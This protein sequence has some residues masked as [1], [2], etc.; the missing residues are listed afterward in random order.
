MSPVTKKK[1][2]NDAIIKW[3][4]TLLPNMSTIFNSVFLLKKTHFYED[5]EET[6]VIVLFFTDR[7]DQPWTNLTPQF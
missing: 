3:C 7:L 2:I 5:P 1:N 6:K 4:Q